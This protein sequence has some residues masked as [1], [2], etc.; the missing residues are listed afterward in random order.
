[1]VRV[2]QV[3]QYQELTAW[4]Q[5]CG[6]SNVVSTLNYQLLA[7]LVQLVDAG[8]TELGHPFRLRDQCQ[9]TDTVILALEG[10]ANYQ[11]LQQHSLMLRRY[12]ERPVTT[13]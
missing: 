12:D 4:T 11:E 5:V 2:R 8:P 6:G 9:L 3:R 7:N 1:M 10:Q 13:C